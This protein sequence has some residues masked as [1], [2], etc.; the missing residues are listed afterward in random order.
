M[1]KKLVLK[2]LETS[3]I[4]F[5]ALYLPPL[6]PSLT[7]LNYS[8]FSYDDL[9]IADTDVEPPSSLSSPSAT[10]HRQRFPPTPGCNVNSNAEGKALPD[11]SAGALAGA[12][13]A[14]TASPLPAGAFNSFSTSASG[15]SIS[16]VAHRTTPSAPSSVAAGASPDHPV[17]HT[18]ALTLEDGVKD[19][20]VRRAPARAGSKRP[21]NPGR[22]ER[23]AS[24]E[25]RRREEVNTT[26]L[27]MPCLPH[28]KLPLF[29]RPQSELW[30]VVQS[31]MSV[32]GA[33]QC[34]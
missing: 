19:H 29:G 25:K 21:L 16:D 5:Y 20:K 26:V 30:I 14:A 4:N 10:G 27:H 24:R 1:K 3:G 8:D 33:Q 6:M 17:N 18:D 31:T 7:V 15:E 28:V 32:Y 2:I 22:M 12:W 23:K 34:G 13:G 11:M 9:G